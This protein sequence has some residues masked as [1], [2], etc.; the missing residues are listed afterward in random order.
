[1]NRTYKP[2]YADNSSNAHKALAAEIVTRMLNLLQNSPETSSAGIIGLRV[3]ALKK[4]SVVV[5]MTAVGSEASLPLSSIE[6]GINNH[7]TN[8]NLSVLDVFGS[9]TVIGM[10]CF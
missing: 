9:V 8:G 3:D 7:I 2:S 6:S 1:M 10:L 4:G 5:D